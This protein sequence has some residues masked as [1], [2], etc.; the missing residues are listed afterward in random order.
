MSPVARM[1]VSVFMMTRAWTETA[2]SGMRP[3][4]VI[5]PSSLSR[6]TVWLSSTKVL[7]KAV[8]RKKSSN[9]KNSVSII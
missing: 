6:L 2:Q 1:A 7:S 4:L 8:E 5:Y 3:C 9:D